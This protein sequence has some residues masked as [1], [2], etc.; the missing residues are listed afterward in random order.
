[1]K[2][3][4]YIGQISETEPANNPVHA[5]INEDGFRCILIRNAVEKTVLSRYD[6]DNLGIRLNTVLSFNDE[7]FDILNALAASSQKHRAC[8]SF[9]A[10][11]SFRM[12][13][14]Y[15]GHYTSMFFCLFQR[16]CKKSTCTHPH[17]STISFAAIRL[18]V[19]RI[20]PISKFSAITCIRISSSIL[21]QIH[22]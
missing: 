12:R 13:M 7:L 1:M 15:L 19:I 5:C 10:F 18:W 20:Q 11:Y 21:L 6:T 8:Y 2:Q 17:S 4:K 14:C 9:R 3:F 16:V 22:D